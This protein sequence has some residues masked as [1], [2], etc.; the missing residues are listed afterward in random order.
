MPKF[1]RTIIVS[2]LS[3]DT[4]LEK[5]DILAQLKIDAEAYQR[6]GESTG[7][8]YYGNNYFLNYFESSRED[9]A[10]HKI[11]ALAYPTYHAS[12]I[13]YEK[14]IPERRFNSW[15]MRY[16]QNDALVQQFFAKH[17]WTSFNP[18]LLKD[19]LLDEFIA[20]IMTYA[21]ADTVPV[22]QPQSAASY[23]KLKTYAFGAIALVCAAYLLAIAFN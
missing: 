10:Q 11:D 13:I 9:I 19:E 22:V 20:I 2:T 5:R 23:P 12:K 1:Y 6:R 15:T 7:I 18:Y 14:G 21:D 8:I 4:P 3:G 16:T 17:G